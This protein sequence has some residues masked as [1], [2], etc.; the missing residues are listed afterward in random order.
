MFSHM[1]QISYSA[2][3]CQ[4]EYSLNI[5]HEYTFSSSGMSFIGVVVTGKGFDMGA[6]HTFCLKCCTTH[7]NHKQKSDTNTSEL[8]LSQFYYCMLEDI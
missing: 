4:T 3:I 8:P 6:K 7:D 2:E 5:H 1:Q